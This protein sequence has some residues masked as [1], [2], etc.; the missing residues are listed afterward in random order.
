MASPPAVPAPAAPRLF[1]DF[2]VRR[3]DFRLRVRL[4]V[5]AEVLVLFG[6]SGSGKTTTLNA[7]AGLITPEQGAIALDGQTLFRKDG[8]AR[9]INLPARQR[10]IGYVFQQYALFPHLTAL[11]N[12]AY[13]LRVAGPERQ[14]R[15]VELLARMN[16]AH[17]AGRYPHELSGGQQQR[18]ALAARWRPRRA[19]SCWTSRSPRWMRPRASASNASCWR[20]N[21]SWDWPWSM[22][23]TGWRTL[24][25]WDSAWL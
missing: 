17:L 21:R 20:Y 11:E 10:H 19:C 15:A 12:V 23:P 18:V 14:G 1:A 6:P 5:S 9:L 2:T 13:S 22:S 3:P 16:L 7:I 8:V 4:E 24:L 25:P